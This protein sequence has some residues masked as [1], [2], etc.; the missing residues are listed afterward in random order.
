VA[1]G[2]GARRLQPRAAEPVNRQRRPDGPC[3]RRTAAG[4]DVAG[5]AAASRRCSCSA[6]S[7]RLR[8]PSGP[9][10]PPPVQ[11]PA[12]RP[13]LG[14]YAVAPRGAGWHR[15]RAARAPSRASRCSSPGSAVDPLPW[16]GTVTVSA[17]GGSRS[18]SGI[19]VVEGWSPASGQS[20]GSPCLSG[21]SARRVR[22]CRF[23]PVGGGTAGHAALPPALPL[24]GQAGGSAQ[25]EPVKGWTDSYCSS[26]RITPLWTSCSATSRSLVLLC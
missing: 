7:P 13:R 12:V 4:V 16:P 24:P 22:S 26:M 23:Y 20:G 21:R 19:A 6:T 2:P 10:S 3:D 18:G 25:V 8:R 15:P 9:L 5:R 1:S 11:L 17:W 14:R